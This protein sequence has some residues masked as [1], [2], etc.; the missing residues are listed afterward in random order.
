MNDWAQ[1]AGDNRV[2]TCLL[3][4]LG[5]FSFHPAFPDGHFLTKQGWICNL[6]AH[7]VLILS[8]IAVKIHSTDHCGTFDGFLP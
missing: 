7:G 2:K 3:S 4:I 6:E 1:K 8:A 5:I